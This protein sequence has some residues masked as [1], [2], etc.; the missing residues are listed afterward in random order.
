M[1]IAVADANAYTSGSSG[2]ARSSS[3]VK[4][5]RGAA[6]TDEERRYEQRDG[7]EHSRAETRQQLIRARSGQGPKDGWTREQ[8][9]KHGENQ[10][11]Q[12]AE[13]PERRLLQH[14]PC[15]RQQSTEDEPAPPSHRCNGNAVKKVQRPVRQH[16]SMQLQEDV[17]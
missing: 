7:S 16:S 8:R 2:M 3:A 5:R 10:Q 12:Q 15:D 9:R 11:H 4:G 17:L 6:R 14:K 13:D 1:N